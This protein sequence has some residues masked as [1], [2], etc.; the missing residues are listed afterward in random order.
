[1]K[2]VSPMDE[3][4]AIVLG[5]RSIF[6]ETLQSLGF[7]AER[8]N[9]AVRSAEFRRLFADQLELRN[10]LETKILNPV[11]R[12]LAQINRQHP[13]DERTLQEQ[14]ALISLL[15]DREARQHRSIQNSVGSAVTVAV[16]ATVVEQME[17]NGRDS[18][19]FTAN[20]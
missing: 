10:K 1:M 6:A 4:H 5:G 8:A 9:F 2:P 17:K 15:P 16:I 18:C 3:Q 11:R 19:E 12:R 20:F 14:T 7:S 13:L